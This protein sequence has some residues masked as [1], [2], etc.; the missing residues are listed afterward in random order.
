MSASTTLVLLIITAITLSTLG[1]GSPVK[2]AEA[3]GEEVRGRV[4]SISRPPGGSASFRLKVEAIGES[5]N[6]LPPGQAEMTCQVLPSERP[7]LDP[8]LQKLQVG[9]F[10]MVSGKRGLV[11]DVEAGLQRVFVIAIF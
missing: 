7:S 2:E 3:S 8:I 10:V 4:T 9:D 6:W 11:G 5:G 1:C